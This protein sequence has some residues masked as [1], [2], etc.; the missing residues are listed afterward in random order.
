M[1]TC[2]LHLGL[3]DYGLFFHLDP[4]LDSLG[5]FHDVAALQGTLNRIEDAQVIMF[6]WFVRCAFLQQPVYEMEEDFLMG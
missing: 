3:S 2:Y 1:K 5:P 4:I 6:F